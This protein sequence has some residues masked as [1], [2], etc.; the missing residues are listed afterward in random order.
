MTKYKYLRKRVKDINGPGLDSKKEFEEIAEKIIED[1]KKGR[2]TKK[3]AKGRLL[4]LYRLTYKK[5]NSKIRF[6]RKT[7]NKLR[8]KIKKMM[9]EL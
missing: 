8:K 9:E 4:L 3:T 2:I 6:G 7:A 1:Y 5:N